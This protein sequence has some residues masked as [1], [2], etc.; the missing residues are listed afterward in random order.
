MRGVFFIVGPTAAG[1]SEL[2]A[3]VAHALGA[4]IISADAFQLYRGFDILSAKPSAATLA[5]AP[6]HLIGEIDPAEEMNVA[7]FASRA[8]ELIFDL[9]GRQK[10]V[11]VVGGT[12]LYVR[13]LTHGLSPLPQGDASLRAELNLKTTDELVEQLTKLDPVTVTTIDLRNRR[14]LI[15]AIEIC[16]ASGAPASAQRVSTEPLEKPIGVLVYREREELLARINQR[17]VRML[18][19]GAIDEVQQP[20]PMSTTSSQMIGFNEIRRL[21]AGEISR[22]ECIE[23]I[24]RATRQYA[25]RQLTWFRGQTNFESLNLSQISVAEAIEWTAR[26]ARLSI[27]HD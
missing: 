15:R 19:E 3:D 5:K 6:H 7:K 4:E 1:K 24:Q 2:A 14:R 25:K 18:D 20:G 13:A 9:R 11:I 17:A 8:R 21:H 16:V 12:G 23:N 27:V 22:D 26:R 10:S